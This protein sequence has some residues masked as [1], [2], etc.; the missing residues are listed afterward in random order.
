M[1]GTDHCGVHSRL[2]TPKKRESPSTA[3]SR[4][5]ASCT[6]GRTKSKSRTITLVVTLPPVS[7][8]MRAATLSTA[9][10]LLPRTPT[11]AQVARWW[12]LESRGMPAVAPGQR[13]GRRRRRRRR[14]R[15]R[16]GSQRVTRH[17]GHVD[18]ANPHPTRAWERLSFRCIT[19][20]PEEVPVWMPPRAANLLFRNQVR[21][22]LVAVALD[23]LHVRVLPTMEVQIPGLLGGTWLR[24]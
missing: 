21:N 15:N 1:K 22:R 11:R 17:N 7:R 24:Q 12:P 6:S 14:T 16:H 8:Q 19:Q 9:N 10:P 3:T 4:R 2:D 23:S 20:T 18:S 5:R 13:E